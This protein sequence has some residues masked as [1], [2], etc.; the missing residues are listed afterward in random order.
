MY[1]YIHIHIS[2]YKKYKENQILEN[3]QESEMFTLAP[4]YSTYRRISRKH[5][6]APKRDKSDEKFGSFMFSIET[7]K[8]RLYILQN[9]YRFTVSLNYCTSCNITYK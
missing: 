6:F 2:I 8:F 3:G 9:K 5:L 7:N 1:I 4:V